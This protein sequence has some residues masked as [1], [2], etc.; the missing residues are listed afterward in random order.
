MGGGPSQKKNLVYK[1]KRTSSRGRR[2]SGGR[3]LL[4]RVNN[5]ASWECA[6][7]KKGATRNGSSPRPRVKNKKRAVGV[8]TGE[9]GNMGKNI[10]KIRSGCDITGVNRLGWGPEIRG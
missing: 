6:Q 7:A 2:N 5:S 8:G 3:R 1:E 9:R 4:V 10:A